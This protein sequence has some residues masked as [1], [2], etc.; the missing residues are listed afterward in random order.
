M[1]TS[2]RPYDAAA[3]QADEHGAQGRHHGHLDELG[4]VAHRAHEGQ[5]Q[6]ADVDLGPVGDHA[7][8]VEEGGV[9]DGAEGEASP[10]RGRGRAD[11]GSAGPPAH[12]LR[13]TRRPRGAGP[14]RNR[15][16][17]VLPMVKAPI[18]MN[19]SW[20]SETCPAKP[21]RRTSERPTMPRARPCERVDRAVVPTMAART[22]MSATRRTAPDRGLAGRHHPGHPSE[23]QASGRGEPGRRDHQ[24]GDEEERDRD[25]LDEHGGEAGIDVAGQ[26]ALR[27]VRDEAEDERADEGHGEA[28]QASDHRGGEAVQ[29]QERQ[30]GRRQAGLP[31]E[32][33]DEHAGEGGEHE[34]QHPAHLRHPV[35]LGPGQRDQLGVIDHRAHGDAQTGPAQEQRRARPRPPPSRPQS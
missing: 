29:R 17:S 22:T 31:D 27:V 7:R 12:R 30:L 6:P 25:H 5:A 21:T 18:P 24:Q 3:H 1:A 34:A 23:G 16:P 20:Q 2:R 15:R 35:R 10:A 13:P 8:V 32:R 28:A 14:T 19:V 4:L 9:H 26:V 11:A 33:G